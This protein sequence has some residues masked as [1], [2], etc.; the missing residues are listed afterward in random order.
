MLGKFPDSERSN[1]M[2][3]VTVDE[4]KKRMAKAEFEVDGIQ[5]GVKEF[6]D[7]F[8]NADPK[9]ATTMKTRGFLKDGQFFGGRN[10][11]IYQPPRSSPA[12]EKI[13]G[14]KVYKEKPVPTAPKE[15]KKQLEDLEKKLKIV[16]DIAMGRLPQPVAT[17]E[18][19]RE[20]VLLSDLSNKGLIKYAS[21]G[22]DFEG[23]EIKGNRPQLIKQIK[24]LRNKE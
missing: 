23:V 8:A 22:R 14:R 2:A 15:L 20:E 1:V 5:S 7:S 24:D 17:Q 12:V 21:S 3:E 9:T 11:T 16:S 4:M 18:V 13:L 10:T 19:P 6:D